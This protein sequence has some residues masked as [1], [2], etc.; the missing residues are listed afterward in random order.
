MK[1]LALLFFF[2]LTATAQITLLQSGTA[3][4]GSGGTITV[5]FGLPSV[6]GDIMVVSEGG[7]AFSGSCP[8][9]PSDSLSTAYTAAY[10]TGAINP[11]FSVYTGTIASAGSN[12]IS[13]PS[14][15]TFGSVLLVEEWTGTIGLSISSGFSTCT[16]CAAINGQ[17]FATPAS[18]MAICI[19][20]IFSGSSFGTLTSGSIDKTVT[21]GN[22]S[23]TAGFQAVSSVAAP[24]TNTWSISGEY[25]PVFFIYNATPPTYVPN[26]WVIVVN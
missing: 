5:S 3:S 2:C 17:T 18:A 12:V 13:F 9:A 11:F 16:N 14:S 25:I 10:T 23:L 24:Y 20:F 21:N 7:Q 8:V 6:I 22:M 4:S 26:P 19:K 1:I 15:C